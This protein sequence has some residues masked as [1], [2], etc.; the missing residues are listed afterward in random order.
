MMST[1]APLRVLIVEKQMLFAKAVA[2]ALSWDPDL[3]VVGIA[4]GRDSA[5]VTG[6]ADIVLVDIDMEEVDEIIT[7]LRSRS[8]G[9]RICALSANAHAESMERCLRAGADAYITKD[10]SLQELLAAIKS[11]DEGSSYVDPRVA[12]PLL[13][14][15]EAANRATN[16][17]TPREREVIRLI[18]AGLSNRDIGRQLVLSE[19]TIENHVSHIFAKTHCRARTQAAVHAIRIGLAS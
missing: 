11:L 9:V 3:K 15:R 17:L 18:A 7:F 19:K 16:R 5:A 14:R 2:Q 8:P 6:E 1:T 10:S 13:G 4:T 12:A